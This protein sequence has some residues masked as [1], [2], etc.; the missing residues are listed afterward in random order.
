MGFKLLHEES[1]RGF[2][3][4]RGI[5]GQFWT[6]SER[7]VDFDPDLFREFESSGYAKAIWSF[8]LV[9]DSGDVTSLRTVTRV[10]CLDVVSGA[11]SGCTGL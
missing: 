10:L 8:D 5:V 1:G 11:D 4:E 7:L 3:L 2:A 6:V 9:P